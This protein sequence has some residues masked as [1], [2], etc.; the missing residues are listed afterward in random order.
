MTIEYHFKASADKVFALLTDPDYLVDRSLA[1]GELSAECSV[2]E[3]AG[4][5]VITMTREV[6]RKLPSFLAKLFDTRQKVELVER[7]KQKGKAREGS[8]TLKV[9]GQPVT[10]SAAL[11]LEPT[12]RS[13]CT[14]TVTHTAKAGIPLIGRKIEGFI[15]EQTADGARAELDHLKNQL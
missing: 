4:G 15:L 13:G 14:Y 1:L 6:E 3:T 5:V 2:D 7:W 10:V 12:G 9:I 11:R 8:Y